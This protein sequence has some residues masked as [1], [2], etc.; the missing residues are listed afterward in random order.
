MNL[1]QKHEP[2]IEKAIQALHARTFY[3]A[4]PEMPKAYDENALSNG[5]TS[6]QNLL[7]KKFNLLLQ[8]PS[9]IYASEEISPYTQ[10]PLGISYPV[11]KAI[12][13]ILASKKAFSQWRKTSPAERAGI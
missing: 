8:E 4:Y 11:Y 12:D 9:E 5:T 10:Q 7:N 1:F 3:A 13:L 6:Y 2:A